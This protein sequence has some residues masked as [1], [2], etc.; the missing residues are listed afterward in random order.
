MPCRRKSNRTI[1]IRL[2]KNSLQA[3]QDSI[4]PQKINVFSGRVSLDT[5]FRKGSL[6][7]E[8]AAVLPLL[9][10]AMVIL[11]SLLDMTRVFSSYTTSLNESAKKLGMYA[12][13]ANYMPDESPVG[14]LSTVSC[15]S[16][17]KAH[18]PS[19]EHVTVSFL[20]SSYQKQRLT[21]LAT[22]TYH[23]PISFLGIS[24]RSFQCCAN[25]HPWT[26]MQENESSGL[27]KTNADMV[28]I[29]DNESVYHTHAD[30]TYLDLSISCTTP[31]QVSSLRNHYG[32]KYSAC[33]N[34]HPEGKES[35]L[36]V[37]DKGEHYHGRANC[38]SLKRTRRMV[39]SSELSGLHKCTR[40]AQRD[41]S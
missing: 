16:Y 14:A 25:V 1:N 40:C 9:F 15:I 17:A 4:P 37:T 38:P 39:P 23:F 41:G 29:T 19:E 10:L 8:A 11:V 3:N 26:G 13:A 34:C 20:G 32:A 22:V 31:G 12:Y 27:D 7:I 24:K 33:P 6:T 28:Y 30:C 36:F 18:L 2:K 5:S 21:L 35:V